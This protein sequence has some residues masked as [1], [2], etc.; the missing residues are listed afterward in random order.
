MS[1]KMILLLLVV[2]MLLTC[3]GCAS[4]PAAGETAAPTVSTAAPTQ[5][6]TQPSAEIQET[7]PP[8]TAETEPP[9]PA[10]P[11]PTQPSAEALAAT[12]HEVSPI[13]ATIWP[14]RELSI[15]ATPSKT[16]KMGTVPA[17]T[18]YCVLS[19]QKGMF[20]VRY[21]DTTG[22]I[23]SSL[24]MINLPD[25]LG[26]LCLYWIT[27]SFGS[28]LTIHDYAFPGVTGEVTGGY[29]YVLQ[30]DGSFLVP[31]LYPC[32]QKLEKAARYAIS[33]GYKLKIY[34][35]YRPGSATLD[36]YNMA[37]E[38]LPQTVPGLDM[39]YEDL[40]TNNGSYELNRFL[41]PSGS[42]HNM[43]IALDLTLVD[44]ATGEDLTMQSSMHD[45]SWYATTRRN[46]DN[47]KLLNKIMEY[48]VFTPLFA[49]WWHFTDSFVIAPLNPKPRQEPISAECWVKDETGWRYRLPDGQYCIDC[50]YTIGETE[51]RFDAN[52]YEIPNQ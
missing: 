27:N 6:A 2:S 50:T 46:N 22:F 33:L 20:E 13:G 42:R 31:F 51:Y 15:Y 11:E 17:C 23:S 47:A 25:Y 52:G 3:V 7:V 1:R 28:V 21:G 38:L 9:A 36:L 10:E 43:G 37:E 4:Q 39:S 48:A 16:G 19:E 24:C 30:P 18:A 45:L 34:D 44:M 14:I 35:S 40:V 8:A 5:A 29:E 12:D 49:E 26:D 41:A 32:A